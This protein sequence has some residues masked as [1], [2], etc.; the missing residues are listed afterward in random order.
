M[1]LDNMFVMLSID[2]ESK[3]KCYGSLGHQQML[4]KNKL[5]TVGG[6]AGQTATNLMNLNVMMNAVKNKL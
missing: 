2:N 4:D 6:Y 1:K 3:A 5:F